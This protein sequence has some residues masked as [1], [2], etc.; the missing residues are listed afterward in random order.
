MKILEPV[1]AHEPSPRS[2]AIVRTPD[3]SETAS[4]SVRFIVAV[5]RPEMSAGRRRL[6][7]DSV[8]HVWRSSTPPCVSI[9]H[10]ENDRFAAENSSAIAAAIVSGNPPP[11]YSGS[12]E[13]EFQPAPTYFA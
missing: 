13:R 9:G 12:N 4:G 6:F 10:N 7:C 5:H 8:P 11:P 1:I 2:C 3:K